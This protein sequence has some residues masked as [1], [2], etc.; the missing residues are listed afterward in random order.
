[1]LSMLTRK[2]ST[3]TLAGTVTTAMEGRW[4]VVDSAQ[5]IKQ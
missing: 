1:M 4:L 3:L 5:D 2:I